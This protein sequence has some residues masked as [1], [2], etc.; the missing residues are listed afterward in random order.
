MSEKN[1]NQPPTP[2]AEPAQPPAQ[3]PAPEGP[4]WGSL[5]KVAAARARMSDAQKDYV[6]QVLD[7]DGPKAAAEFVE[8]F[9]IEQQNAPRP[10]PGRPGTAALPGREFSHPRTQREYFEICRAAGKGDIEAMRTRAYL[11]KDKRFSVRDL[12]SR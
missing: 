1:S 5:E 2:P 4:D 7:R 8:A 9:T 12:P 11:L 6:T 3:P 10:P